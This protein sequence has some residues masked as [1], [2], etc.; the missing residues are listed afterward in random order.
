MRRMKRTPRPNRDFFL[1]PSGFSQNTANAFQTPSRKKNTPRKLDTL[2][3]LVFLQCGYTTLGE[4]DAIRLKRNMRV[5]RNTG[6]GPITHSI[7]APVLSGDPRRELVFPEKVAE[8][9]NAHYEVCPDSQESIDLITG[10]PSNPSQCE[11]TLIL[12][13]S[14]YADKEKKRDRDPCDD[15]D[16]RSDIKKTVLAHSGCDSTSSA[17]IT[18]MVQDAKGFYSMIDRSVKEGQALNAKSQEAQAFAEAKARE[19]KANAEAEKMAKREKEE[20][21]AA[22]RQV[23]TFWKIIR[24]RPQ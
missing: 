2:E 19:A 4:K 14:A 3:R 21:E 24:S 6:Q 1:D 13:E 22:S 16:L 15:D 10:N 7:F 11:G 8:Q 23:S 20:M 12:P 5:A 9:Y 17:L 18:A